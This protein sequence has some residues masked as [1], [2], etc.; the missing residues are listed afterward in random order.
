[1]LLRLDL[2]VFG[3]YL[4]RRAQ[5]FPETL[6]LVFFIFIFVLAMAGIG[7][8]AFDYIRSPWSCD[9]RDGGKWC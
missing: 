5:C 7:V 4:L 2:G 6:F 8:G 1:M 9:A 3:A